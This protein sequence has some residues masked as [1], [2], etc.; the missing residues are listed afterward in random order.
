MQ[1]GCA[2]RRHTQQVQAHLA[3]CRALM[4]HVLTAPISVL[5]ALGNG[6]AAL[7]TTLLK[8][9]LLICLSMTLLCSAELFFAHTQPGSFEKLNSISVI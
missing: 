6:R 4:P 9:T 1:Q 8:F 2:R 5:E 7:D 3:G